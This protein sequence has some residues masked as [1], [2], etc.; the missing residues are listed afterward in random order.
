MASA[1]EEALRR[2]AQA[3]RQLARVPSQAAAEAS[4]DI[5]ELVEQEFA[6]GVDPYG[7]AWA[8]LA[9]ATIAKGRSAPPLTDTGAMRGGFEA[10]PMSG[11][12]IA[13]SFDV[14]YAAF[15]QTGTANMP[16]RPPLPD[17]GLPDTWRRAIA[18]AV[19]AAAERAMGAV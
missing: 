10:R 1:G 3:V 12:G 2:V 15:H 19:D 4:A 9:P 14:D 11:A 17:H 5:A 6:A 7:Q 8:P 18:D 16:A 13:V